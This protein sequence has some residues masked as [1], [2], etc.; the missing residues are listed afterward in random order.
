ML[1]PLLGL[2]MR[3]EPSCTYSWV[4]IDLSS[5]FTVGNGLFLI[6]TCNP[7]IPISLKTS[8]VLQASYFFGKG[9]GALE[10]FD[11][12]TRKFNPPMT[13]HPKLFRRKNK[14]YARR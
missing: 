10:S 7:R 9:V 12:G 2:L 1:Q 3:R 5:A 11:K 8:D 6:Y 4:A 14:F 13:A